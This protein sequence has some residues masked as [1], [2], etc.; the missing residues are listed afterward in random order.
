MG[1]QRCTAED[2]LDMVS[3]GV[4]VL[5]LL[6]GGVCPVA[7]RHSFFYEGHIPPLWRSHSRYGSGE[8]ILPF[9]SV[10]CC[11]WRGPL[12]VWLFILRHSQGPTY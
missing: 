6:C 10:Q 9:S 3:A 4:H 7:G 8:H 2:K 1:M 12:C 5:D 11:R